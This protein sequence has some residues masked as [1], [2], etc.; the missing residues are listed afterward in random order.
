MK[1]EKKQGKYRKSQK[2][3]PYTKVNVILLILGFA[4]LGAGYL[5][6]SVKPWNSFASMNIAP[7]LLVLGYCVVL[8]LAILYHKREAKPESSAPSAPASP[9]QGN[10]PA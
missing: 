2:I 4:L 8:P 5:A 10:P 7:I 9:Q 6:L 1:T 3:L